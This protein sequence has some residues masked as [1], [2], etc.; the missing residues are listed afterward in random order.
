MDL[1][2]VLTSGVV[3]ALISGL[4]TLRKNERNIIIENITQERT[5]WRNEIREKNIEV[6]K[7][8]TN[9]SKKDELK[10]IKSELRLLLNPIDPLDQD[11][12]DELD[13]LIKNGSKEDDVE[14]FTVKLSL[15]LKHDWERAKQ[16]ADASVFYKF[17]NK[18]K[19][20]R[21]TYEQF[22]EKNG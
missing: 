20:K 22:I 3:A 8:F 5:K 21:I 9:A 7:A 14:R 13:T 10:T 15:L 18:K 4:V 11:I 6:Q 17:K 1:S 19:A 2:T 16:E 12:I